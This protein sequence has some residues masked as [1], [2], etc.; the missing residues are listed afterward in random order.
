M[1]KLTPILLILVIALAAC[2]GSDGET[3]VEPAPEETAV[4]DAA[5]S[6]VAAQDA[7]SA[8]DGGPTE[9][10][11]TETAVPAETAPPQPDESPTDEAT[12]ASEATA[13][14]GEGWG[15]SGTTAQTACDHPYFP[16]RMGTTW[17]MSGGDGEPITWEVVDVAGDLEAATAE[18]VM[19]SAGLEF[20]YTF[21]CT[22][23]GGLSSFTFAS[24]G[25]AA[26]GPE[27]E[28]EI[29][30]GSGYF[31]PDPGL[32]QPGYSWDTAFHT[33]YSLSQMNGDTEME[34]SGEMDTKQT[35][36][37]VSAEPVTFQNRTVPGLVIQQ[38]TDVETAMTMLG[39]TVESS[40]FLGAETVF[41]R[42]LGILRQ[43]SFTDFGE[44]TMEVTDNYIP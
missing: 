21:D 26:L 29:T 2:G 36:R 31:L 44:F 35:S 18:L 5:S 6:V 33:T 17:T 9:V 43:T 25:L 27:V 1:S 37:V 11:A 40:L 42:G 3:A 22:A 39:E 14:M 4:V 34:I 24:Q 28:V 13:D 12:P 8:E 32:L 10:P 19:R 20:N 38:D 23:G 30:D 7:P 15:E 41:G 16:L